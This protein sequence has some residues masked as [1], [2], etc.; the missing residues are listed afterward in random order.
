MRRLYLLRFSTIN[1][2]NVKNE[3]FRQP[4]QI[5]MVRGTWRQAPSSS[6]KYKI[7]ADIITQRFQTQGEFNMFP[8]RIIVGLPMALGLLIPSST[9]FGQALPLIVRGKVTMKDGAPPPA[10]VG[11]QRI[12]SDIQGS[13]PGPLTSKNGDY[14]WRMDVDPMRTRRCWLQAELAGFVSSRV[15]IS[16]LNGYTSATMDLPPIILGPA[17]PDARTINASESDV[18][19]KSKTAW[20][21]A[22]KA[23]DGDNLP[24]AEKQL[25]S[26]VEASPK[27]ARGWHTLGII[28]QAEQKLPKARD[29]YQHAVDADPKSYAS[30]VTLARVL[31]KTKDW[32]N[33]AKVSD[34]LI[35]LDPKQ[36]YP[37]IYLHQ[38]VAL[39]KLKDLSGAEAAAKEAMRTS[40]LPRAEFV[41]GRIAEAK[42]DLAGA[43][44]H[45]TS[46]IAMDPMAPDIELIKSL[47]QVVGKPE[48]AGIDPDLELP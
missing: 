10:S 31:I 32:Q 16:N 1:Q 4:R 37:E 14:V 42:G 29:A 11:I 15:E 6:W 41:L 13:A 19:A 26:V 25:Q 34:A 5:C 39:L 38:S 47:L 2:K 36:T 27:F 3:A 33:A 17:I 30:Y 24:E 40:K 48:A 22:M 44:E 21:A 28:C 23:V 8:A 7:V 45:I 46:Y 12:C 18:P 35:K 20:K 43:R 9:A